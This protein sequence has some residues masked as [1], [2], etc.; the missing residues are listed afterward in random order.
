MSPGESIVADVCVIGGGP[1]GSTIAHRLASL[2]HD[3]CVIERQ[4]F[5][6]HHVGASLPSS[7]L[8]LLEMIGARDLVER[9]GF[10]RPRQIAVWWAEDAPAIRTRPGVPGFHVDRGEF[11]RLLLQ[12]AEANGVR[13]LQ[14]ARAL[15]PE[16]LR[17][18]GWRIRFH[19]DGGLKELSAR[20]VVDACGGR[21]ILPGRRRRVSAPLLALYA[22]WQS[23]LGGETMGRV[24]AGE[25]EWFWH[26]PMGGGKSVAAVFVDPKRLSGT[27]AEHIETTYQELLGRCRL[28][29]D[30]L[31]GGIEGPVK[32]CDASSRCAQEPVA[33]D[34]VRVGDAN[35]SVDPLSSQGVQLAI[36]GAIQAAVVVNTLVR[37]PENSNA[38]VV[39]YKDRQME[40]VQ[41]YAAKTAAFYRER[42][43]VCDQPFWRRRAVLAEGAT[44][45]DLS[46]ERLDGNCRIALSGSATIEQTPT[47]EGELIVARPAL[48]HQALQR[49]VAYL[50][51][52]EIVPLLNRIRPGQRA[53]A[54]VQ[55]WSGQVPS[56]NG[57]KMMQWLWDR[58]ILVPSRSGELKLDPRSS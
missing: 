14:P 39:F 15:P 8:P 58:R 10:L 50:D 35:L 25:N 28:F 54:V 47:I 49:P 7:I 52:V 29:R 9:A 57:W 27:T 37:C 51:G 13:V 56:E 20:F 22:H 24:E 45:P 34:F 41:Q 42:A 33:S 12:S 26:A 43:T 32:A 30:V 48:H 31:L 23:A 1:A 3:V 40:K 17:D 2:G 44:H 55:S 4:S 18:G 11:D 5:P 46:G 53:R 38:A 21:G 6:R 19:Q 36:A 16:R